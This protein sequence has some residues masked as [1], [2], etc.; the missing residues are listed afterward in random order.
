[1]S[2]LANFIKSEKPE[3][4]EVLLDP[5]LFSEIK[6]SNK[7]VQ[8]FIIDNLDKV[9]TYIVEEPDIN[10]TS[11]RGLNLPFIVSELFCMNLKE[12]QSRLLVV[13]TTK[14]C[15]KHKTDLN[16]TN[17][18]Y[19]INNC[20]NNSTNNYDHLDLEKKNSTCNSNS[21][22]KFDYD[23]TPSF[24]ERFFKYIQTT[25]TETL[26]KS[27]L[28]GYCFKIIKKLIKGSFPEFLRVFS[29]KE[30][31][32]NWFVV[33]KKQFFWTLLQIFLFCFTPMKLKATRILNS[34]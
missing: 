4:E 31:L 2:F 32:K 15:T 10:C 22:H 12:L 21:K 27:T 24:L 14:S 23:S 20:N 33:W 30:N 18:N 8:N 16:I 28:P 6:E 19:N 3:V 34:I 25:D 11:K 29:E 13:H 7:I 26:I 1:M 9:L 17:T 5:E